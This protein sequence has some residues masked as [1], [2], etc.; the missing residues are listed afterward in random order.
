MF[1]TFS[2]QQALSKQ[3]GKTYTLNWC[4]WEGH[5]NYRLTAPWRAFSFLPTPVRSPEAWL[6]SLSPHL[7]RSLHQ[8]SKLLWLRNVMVKNNLRI[9]CAIYLADFSCLEHFPLKSML[10][11][12]RPLWITG[13]D[14]KFNRID[15]KCVSFTIVRIEAWNKSL[16]VQVKQSWKDTQKCI[17]YIHT[18][19]IQNIMT[20]YLICRWS[21]LCCQKQR[22]PTEA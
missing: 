13:D 18:Q 15:F 9:L 21:S 19:M 17:Q 2:T 11:S 16:S 22:Q 4:K 1:T 5:R 3:G 14:Q 12:I 7:P 8:P 10:S 6:A 20:T